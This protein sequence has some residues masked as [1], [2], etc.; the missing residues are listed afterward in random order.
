VCNGKL[1]LLKEDLKGLSPSITPFGKR[2]FIRIVEITIPNI[3]VLSIRKIGG[4]NSLF[5][6]TSKIKNY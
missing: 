4:E 1:K 6:S 3:V 2:K 5:H